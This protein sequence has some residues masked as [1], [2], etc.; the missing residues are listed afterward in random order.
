MKPFF[1]Y[2]LECSD[3]SYYVGHTDNIDLRIAQHENKESDYTS[4]RL[5]IKVVFVQTC[6]SR[7]E[8]IAAEIKIKGWSRKKK[9]ALVS[10]N[11]DMLKL[12]SRRF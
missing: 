9:E 6:A 8:A 11:W 3:Y 4:L 1:V 12:F 2:I 5:P 10:K 7:Y